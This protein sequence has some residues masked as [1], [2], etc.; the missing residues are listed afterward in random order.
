MKIWAALYSDFHPFKSFFPEADRC[1]VE[2]PTELTQEPGFLVIWG[3]G[4]IHPSLYN[5][6]NIASYVGTKPSHRDLIEWQ[7]MLQAVKLQIPI[8]GVC[9][10]AQ[11][12]CAMA[13]G[14]LVQDVTGHTTDHF[15]ETRDQKRLLTSS[16][17]H[18]M[19]YLNNTVAE[20]IAWTSPNLSQHYVGVEINPLVEPEIVWFPTI[21]CLAIQGH[22][23][24]MHQRTPFNLYVY[25]LLKQYAYTGS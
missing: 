8:V 24:F 22:P 9:R 19:M 3:G 10:G 23:E 17:H 13:G 18:Q 16:L 4:D 25:S 6:P 2:N 1:C 21:R 11:M 15:V 12:G 5:Q 20:L 14:Q 7:L